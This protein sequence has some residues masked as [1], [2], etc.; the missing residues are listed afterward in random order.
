[1]SYHLAHSSKK[2]SPSNELLFETLYSKFSMEIIAKLF[3]QL[4][5]QEADAF[6]QEK[7]VTSSAEI[8]RKVALR[9]QKDLIYT[10]LVSEFLVWSLLHPKKENI[11]LPQSLKKEDILVTLVHQS[12]QRLAYI[13]GISLSEATLK[14]EAKRIVSDLTLPALF[15]SL[16]KDYLPP[17]ADKH[18]KDYEVV[19]KKDDNEYRLQLVKKNTFESIFPTSTLLYVMP[20]LDNSIFLHM[21]QVIPYDTFKKI[22]SS[23]PEKSSLLFQLL[24]VYTHGEVYVKDLLSELHIVDPKLKALH[25]KATECFATPFTAGSRPYFSLYPELEQHLGSKGSYL[26]LH[27]QAGIFS[28][29]PLRSY[30]FIQDALERTLVWLKEA[31]KAGRKLTVLFWFPNMLPPHSKI[32]FHEGE[33]NVTKELSVFHYA[34]ENFLPSLETSPYLKDVFV[35]FPGE[36]LPKNTSKYLYKVFVLSSA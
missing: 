17:L 4:S 22:H 18:P 36:K 14:K 27:P 32:V 15:H 2:L 6:L 19:G 5:I 26:D 8:S 3:A 16:S 25:D 10:Y 13:H 7:N 21:E 28:M 12:L 33:K 24:Q 9:G 31:E 30:I 11:F 23:H 35:Y 29:R 1:M 34:E 20:S